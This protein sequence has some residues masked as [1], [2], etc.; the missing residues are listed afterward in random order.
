VQIDHGVYAGL[1]KLQFRNND[2][3]ASWFGKIPLTPYFF[4]AILFCGLICA[5]SAPRKQ[6]DRNF[7]I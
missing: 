5:K 3:L 1:S 4:T 7:I 2:I 6:N